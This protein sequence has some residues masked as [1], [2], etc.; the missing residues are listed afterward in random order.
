MNRIISI[1]LLA[2]IFFPVVQKSFADEKNSPLLLES[3]G[4]RT[5]DYGEDLRKEWNAL[6][7]E[8]E[9]L[10]KQAEKQMRQDVLP[11]LKKE[12]ERLRKWLRDFELKEERGEPERT[13]T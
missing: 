12:L 2:W 8:L 11:Y 9:K 5:G 10:E 1:L 4:D 3:A 7:R 6:L 13:R